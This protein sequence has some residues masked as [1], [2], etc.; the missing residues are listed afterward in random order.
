[1][2]GMKEYGVEM[3]LFVVYSYQC[4]IDFSKRYK[5]IK[6]KKGKMKDSSFIVF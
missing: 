1:M 5:V 4:K 2:K 3:S 6:C